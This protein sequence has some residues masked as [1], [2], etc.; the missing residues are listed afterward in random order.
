VYGSLSLRLRVSFSLSHFS[1]SWT[2]FF[3][4]FSRL[5]SELHESFVERDGC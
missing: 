4:I 3:S 2:I 1:F 5:A